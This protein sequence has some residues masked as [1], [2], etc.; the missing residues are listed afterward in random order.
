VI[1]WHL[2]NC[3][4]GLRLAVGVFSLFKIQ[5]F[6]VRIDNDASVSVAQNNLSS[7]ALVAV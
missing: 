6:V 7:D 1:G 3:A 4:A 2:Q 5:S